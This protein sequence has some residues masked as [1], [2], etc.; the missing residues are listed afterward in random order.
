MFDELNI[1]PVVGIATGRLRC[2]WRW[3]AGSRRPC[4]REWW[5][6]ISLP[7]ARQSRV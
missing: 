6:A 7:Q 5:R 1:E 4:D 2:E 3:A